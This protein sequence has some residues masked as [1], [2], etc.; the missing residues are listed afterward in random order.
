MFHRLDPHVTCTLPRARQ[1]Q[2][3]WHLCPRLWPRPASMWGV[4]W[5]GSWWIRQDY[6][7]ESTMDACSWGVSYVL[8]H[9]RRECLSEWGCGECSVCGVE[10]SSIT[11]DMGTCTCS[12]HCS[13][14]LHSS[15]LLLPNVLLAPYRLWFFFH[16]LLIM[17]C[18]WLFML[19]CC[20]S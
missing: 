10:V 19:L 5:G 18:W 16:F 8:C 3:C 2:S 17:T 12:I 11:D 14:L 9:S 7:K 20:V 4:R 6:R 1:R 13:H 15:M